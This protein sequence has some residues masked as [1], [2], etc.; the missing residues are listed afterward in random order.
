MG[1]GVWIYEGLLHFS[2]DD[3]TVLPPPPEGT[4]GGVFR[5]PTS[6]VNSIG[7]GAARVATVM[8]ISVDELLAANRDGLIDVANWAVDPKPGDTSAMRFRITYQDRSFEITQGRRP[9]AE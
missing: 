9:V 8:R 2:L 1:R 3:V 4:L 7:F 5:R 6:G